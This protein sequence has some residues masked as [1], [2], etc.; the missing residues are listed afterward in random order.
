MSHNSIINSGFIE[1][2]GSKTSRFVILSIAWFCLF[3][4]SSSYAAVNPGTKTERNPIRVL[5]STLS[6]LADRDQAVLDWQ[7]QEFELVFDLPADGWY[8]SLDLFLTAIPEGNVGTTDPITIS[9]NGE[10]P[11]SLYGKASRFDAHIKLDPARIRTARNSLKIRYKT[12]HHSDCLTPAHGKWILDLGRSKLAT[13]TRSK[14]R[15]LHIVELN[16]RLNHPMTAPKRVAI[17]AIGPQ[18]TALEAL[19][20]QGIASRMDSIPSFQ[21]TSGTADLEIL[22]GEQSQISNQVA[23]KKMLDMSMTRIFTDTGTRPKL[24]LTAQSETEIMDLARSFAAHELPTVRRRHA[25]LNE[26]Y[27]S[28]PFQPHAVIGKGNYKLAEI[29]DTT[30]EHSWKPRAAE[31]EFN[32]EN[33]DVSDGQLT[34]NIVK[35]PVI[36]PTSRLKVR[37]NDQS[38]GYT[39]LDKKQKFVSFDIKPGMFR[40]A[41]NKITIEPV[42]TAPSETFSCVALNEKPALMVSNRSKLEIKSTTAHVEANLNQFAASGAP[43]FASSQSS[44]PAIVLTAKSSKD[45]AA[46]LQFMAHAAQQFGPK[47]ANAEYFTQLPSENDRARNILV[48]GPN[49]ITDEKL[50]SSAPSALRLALRGKPTTGPNTL[51]IASIERYANIDDALAVERLA[52]RLAKDTR[53]STGGIAAIFASPYSDKHVVGVITSNRPSQYAKAMRSLT[54]AGYWNGLQGSVARWDRN[55]IMMAQTASILPVSYGPQKP[56]GSIKEK[57]ASAIAAGTDK[58]QSAFT[59]P[60]PSPQFEPISQ[61]KRTPEQ[62]PIRAKSPALELRGTSTPSAQKHPVATSVPML[63]KAKTFVQN[64]YTTAQQKIISFRNNDTRIVAARTWLDQQAHNRTTLMML[65][66]LSIVLLIGLATPKLER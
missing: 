13:K 66:V 16:Q 44:L 49:A 39:K 27:A 21:F 2:Y 55:T 3:F 51:R 56:K 8:E 25:T 46:S 35:S 62:L 45:R 59:R 17:R 18:K 33:P 34:L 12:P 28:P 11:I 58:I 54:K 1:N 24:V 20:A 9:Y 47:F 23:D 41:K 38:I 32:V 50:L 36:G 63:V 6:D 65:I 40:S 61:I 10:T 52:Q 57:M 43:L 15:D 7:D 29:G 26:L 60:K 30:F 42:I 31:L 14:P 5:K 53:I 22:V 19:I 4:A 64:G 48:I 37:L